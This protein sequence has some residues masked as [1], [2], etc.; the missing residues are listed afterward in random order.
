[1]AEREI[2]LLSGMHRSGTSALARVFNLAGAVLPEPLVAPALGNELGHWEPAEAVAMND[3]ALLA[4]GSDV[5]SL[6]PLSRDWVENGGGEAFI[7]EVRAWLERVAPEGALTVVK[8]PRIARL[9]PFWRTAVERLGARPRVVVAWRDPWEVARS[10][11]SRQLAH[12][13]DEVWPPARVELLWLRHQLD[14]ERASRGAPRSFVA[15]ADVLD[16][17]R[18]LLPRVFSDLDLPPPSV[19]APAKLEID[20]FLR[21]EARRQH[22]RD[23]AEAGGEIARAVRLLEARVGDPVG[24]AKG[25]DKAAARLDDALELFGGYL[26]ALE[27]RVAADAAGGEAGDARTLVAALGE[28]V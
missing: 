25:F 13:P 6:H 15:Y 16:D 27:T 20:G 22:R 10:L 8:D 2:V 4:A 21:P 17:W 23:E 26:A 28:A 9:A 24:G 5:N 7:E 11:S 18:A 19:D 1:M 12:F 3:A 14:L